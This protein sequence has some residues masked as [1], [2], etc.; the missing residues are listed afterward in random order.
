VTSRLTEVIIDCHD[1]ERAAD[2]WCAVLGYQRGRGGEGWLS[3]SAWAED[4]GPADDQLRAG[5]V[6]PYLAF[7]LVP[8]T[9]TVKNRV[10]VDV[11][12]VD[13]SRDEEVDR[14]IALGARRADIG[15]GDVPWVVMAD[16]EGNE[17]CVMR[18]LDPA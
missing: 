11:T 7:V 10:H 5:A 12:P 8:E 1:L 17:F 14:L 4:G 2:F 13:R 16:P 6:P 3:I 18:A 15:Q 9:K